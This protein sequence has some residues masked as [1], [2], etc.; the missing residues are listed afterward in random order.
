M[1]GNSRAALPAHDDNVRTGPDDICFVIGR[2]RSGTT[3]FRKML[4]T[5]PRMFDM[6]EIFN[7][8]NPNSYFRFLR[9]RQAQDPDALLP[10]Q[11][12]D[13]FLA[14]VRRCR[15]KSLR[16]RPDSR[17]VVLDV[18]YDQAHLLCVPWW[19]ITSL[20]RVFSL[21]REQEWRVIDIHRKDGAGMFVSNRVAIETGIYHSKAITDGSGQRARVHIDP[22]ALIRQ[23]KTTAQ[24]YERVTGHFRGYDKYRKVIYEEMF[25]DGGL[26]RPALLDGLSTFFGVDNAFDPVPRLTKMLVDDIFA[27]VENAEEIRNVL[28]QHNMLRRP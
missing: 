20:P 2:P 1:T 9:R 8:S 3:V 7:E 23:L 22:R 10:S 17:V 11:S 26:F 13:N 14:Y 5:H 25:D 4:D 27:H 19:E 15:E 16:K 24:A 21:I 6:G 28:G 12:V 18:K